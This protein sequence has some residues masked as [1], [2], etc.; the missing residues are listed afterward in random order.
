[1]M[2][3]WASVLACASPVG[4]EEDS[5][6]ETSSAFELGP[7]RA[8]ESPQQLS[9]TEVSEA[10]GLQGPDEQPEFFGEGGG[11]LLADLNGDGHLDLVYGLERQSWLH[12]GTGPAAFEPATDLPF[13]GGFALSPAGP[14]KV[15]LGIERL[16]EVDF[17]Q[18]DLGYS[19]L[20]APGTGIVRAPSVADFDGDGWLDLY[21]GI[22]HP[23]P[24]V[25]GR[26]GGLR[27]GPRRA[28]R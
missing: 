14:S 25:L 5:S 20:I 19:E 22:G 8:C 10:L 23:E 27:A 2:P 3:M 9:F 7:V 16:A 18:E 17:G 24:S 11:T 26:R 1:M 21:V 13:A 28:E 15:L 4:V 6:L 12:W